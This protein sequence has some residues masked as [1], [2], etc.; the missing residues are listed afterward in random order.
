MK[1]INEAHDSLVLS[2]AIIA[3]GWVGLKP[4][5]TRNASYSYNHISRTSFAFDF[6]NFLMSLMSFFFSLYFFLFCHSSPTVTFLTTTADRNFC[7]N[8]GLYF[9][10]LTCDIV[11]FLLTPSFSKMCTLVCLFDPPTVSPPSVLLWTWWFFFPRAYPLQRT[12]CP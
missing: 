10:R 4:F 11:V 7:P 6:W 8:N 9:M 5:S 1:E 12:K 3:L 2:V